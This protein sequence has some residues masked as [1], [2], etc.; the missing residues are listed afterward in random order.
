MSHI[1]VQDDKTSPNLPLPYLSPPKIHIYPLNTTL[2]CLDLYK[3]ADKAT[4]S[5][6]EKRI[7]IDTNKAVPCNKISNISF[8]EFNINFLL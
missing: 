8:L 2:E 4:L 6:T 1:E 3:N 5:L 7:V